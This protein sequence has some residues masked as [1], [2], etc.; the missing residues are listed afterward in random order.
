MRV[1]N[2]DKIPLDKCVTLKLFAMAPKNIKPNQ[3]KMKKIYFTKNNDT[4]FFYL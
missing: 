2:L 3:Q 4:H 1:H